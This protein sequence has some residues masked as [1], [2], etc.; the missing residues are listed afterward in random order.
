MALP[1]GHPL[2]ARAAADSEGVLDF[3]ELLDEPFLALPSEAGPLRGYWLA[4][5]ARGDRAP[6]RGGWW[7]AP[8][9]P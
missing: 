9:R 1:Q 3:T 7:A 6:R 2:A 5:D 8:R 4:L